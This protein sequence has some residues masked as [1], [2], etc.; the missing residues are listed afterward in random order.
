M[1]TGF[2]PS[3]LTTD[4]VCCSIA[5]AHPHLQQL[6]LQAFCS[7]YPFAASVL[8]AFSHNEG[9]EAVCCKRTSL[10]GVLTHPAKLN[11]AQED[12]DIHHKHWVMDGFLHIRSLLCVFTNV[13]GDI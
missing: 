9:R 11:G 10:S 12:I 6:L 7:A 3:T 8:A 5:I 4:A 1:M 13:A 2:E